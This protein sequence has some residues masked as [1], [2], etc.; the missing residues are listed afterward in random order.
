MI[1]QIDSLMFGLGQF[2]YDIL[3]LSNLNQLK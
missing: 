1:L 3:K 2:G